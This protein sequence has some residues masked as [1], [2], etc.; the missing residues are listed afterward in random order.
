M[1]EKLFFSSASA[2][3]ATPQALFDELNN[4]YHFDLDPASTDENAKCA[5]HFTIADDGLAQ[6]WGGMQSIL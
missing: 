3:W 4:K 6:D 5:R 1:N 2:E